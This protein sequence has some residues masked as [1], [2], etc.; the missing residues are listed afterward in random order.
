MH[1]RDKWSKSI[2]RRATIYE[3]GLRTP[4]STRTEAVCLQYVRTYLH[5]VLCTAYGLSLSLGYD[6][7]YQ[8]GSLSTK[9]REQ[10]HFFVLNSEL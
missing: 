9:G 1:P 5:T 6:R 10:V 3:P 2:L 8:Q 7:I 4:S